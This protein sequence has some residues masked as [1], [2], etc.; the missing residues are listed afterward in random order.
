ML[1]TQ[2][3]KNAAE[4]IRR[5]HLYIRRNIGGKHKYKEDA[6]IASTIAY[7]RREISFIDDLTFQD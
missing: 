6:D 5:V 7:I 1:I 4:I 3:L 2:E